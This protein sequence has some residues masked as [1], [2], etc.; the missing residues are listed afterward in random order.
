M[1]LQPLRLEAGWE[2][3]YNLF[4]EIDPLKGFENY[5]EGSSLLCLKNTRRQKIID[6]C[7][8][9]ELDING[10]YELE[11]F[12]YQENFNFKTNDFDTNPNWEKPYLTFSTK[13]RIKLVEKLEEIMRTL[14]IYKDPR[15]FKKRGIV[16]E[17]SE[18]YRVQLEQDGITNEILSK[19]INN[20]NYIIQNLAL[21]HKDITRESIL[22][23]AEQGIT[24][25]VKNKANQKL[26]SKKFNK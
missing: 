24:K 25:K 12:N 15:I 7:W 13:N 20:G 17:P 14:P 23:F 21:D 18:S 11:V 3:T 1:K 5:F 9:P 8:R 6:V 2:V 22:I 4:Y 16:D 26:N 10:Q 19:I